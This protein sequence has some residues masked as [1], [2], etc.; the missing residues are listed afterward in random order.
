MTRKELNRIANEI[1]T[2]G[3]RVIKGYCC[4]QDFRVARNYHDPVIEIGTNTGVY[5]W[6]WTV[7][8]SPDYNILFVDGYRNF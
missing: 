2:H 1:V 5:G 4:L 6:N 3:G 8:Y 7:Y